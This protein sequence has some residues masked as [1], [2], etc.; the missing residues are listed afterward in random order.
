MKLIIQIPCLDEE[1]TLPITLKDL[2][3]E[4]NGIDS[5]EILVIDDGSKDKTVE[6]AREHNV[7]HILQL[8]NNKGLA[9]AFSYGIN[10]SL[11][12]G[13]DIIVNT[14]ADNQYCG[15]DIPKLIQPILDGKADIVIGDRQVETIKHFSPLKVFLQKFGSWVVR[16]VS[17]TNIPDATSGFRAY[18]REAALQINVVSDF[19]YTIETIISAGKKNLAIDHVPIRTNAKLRESRL[20]PNIRA[21]LQRAIIT[22]IKVYSMYKP[23]KVFTL[24]GGTFFLLGFAIGCRYLYFF[25]QDQ[26]AGHIQS[27][28]LS[29]ILLIVGFQIIMMGIVAELIS[30]NRQLLEDI[31]QRTKKMNYD[32]GK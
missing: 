6:V 32:S 9:K 29:A 21:Y 25:F 10:H 27:L 26:T 23:L 17:G 4:I 2:P 30:I 7:G 28:I 20:F 11:K 16:Q 3:K 5:I 1:E 22:I 24:V 15:G 31:Q 12:L 14:D 19:T 8:T 18:S 13:A